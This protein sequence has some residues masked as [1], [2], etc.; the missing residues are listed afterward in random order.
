MQTLFYLST[1]TDEN[2]NL[3]SFLILIIPD[4]PKCSQTDKENLL[5][6]N[7]NSTEDLLPYPRIGQIN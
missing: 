2:F 6:G 3:V 5:Q 7:F 1:E 4:I